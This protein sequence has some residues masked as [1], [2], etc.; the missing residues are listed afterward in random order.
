[1]RR[2]GGGGDL[3]SEDKVDDVGVVSELLED[4]LLVS[5]G[6][7]EGEDIAAGLDGHWDWDRGELG[8]TMSSLWS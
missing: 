4:E 2:A 6:V 3:L 1:M 7:V 8:N 5:G